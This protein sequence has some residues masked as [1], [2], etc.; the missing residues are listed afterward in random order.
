MFGTD[1]GFL[2][3]YDMAEEYRQLYLTGLSFRD[4]LAM[5]TTAP[6]QRFHVADHQGELRPA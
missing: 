6:A 3:D 5:L 1:T 4:V 2:T